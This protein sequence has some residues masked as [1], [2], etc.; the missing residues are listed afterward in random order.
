MM[1]TKEQSKCPLGITYAG[2][3]RTQ[4][5][6]TQCNWGIK[7]TKKMTDLGRGGPSGR[8]PWRPLW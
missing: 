5:V 3:L 7:T 4:C 1:S 2:G 6:C 8:E